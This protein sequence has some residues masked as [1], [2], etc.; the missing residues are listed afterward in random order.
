M[1]SSPERPPLVSP[2]RRASQ[3]RRRGRRV[4]PLSPRSA[5][6]PPRGACP[7]RTAARPRRPA[8]PATSA[9]PAT[10]SR[11][12]TSPSP[13]AATTAAAGRRHHH[14]RP[15]HRRAATPQPR[16]HPRHRP[17]RARST[18]RPP[19]SP[20]RARTW[21]SPP[22][23]RVPGGRRLPDHRRAHQRPG[24]DGASGG[25]VRTRDG[26]AMANQADAA[27]RV[28]PCNDH[29][30][31]KARF[32]FRDH[33]ARGTSRSSRT[34]CRPG[35]A[36]AGGHAPPGR[37]ASPTPWPPSSRRSPSAAPPCCTA[38]ARTGCRCATSCPQR[39]AR[40]SRTLAGEAPPGS[41]PGWRSK[42]GRYPFETYGVLIADATT[43][44]ELETQTLSLFETRPLHRPRLPAVVRRVDHG[45]RAGAPVV[46]R[47]RQPAPLV[48]PVAQRG[49]CHLVRGAVR[50]AARRD[51]PLDERMRARLRA[52]RRLARRRA[53]RPPRPSRPSPA[54]RSASSARSSTTAAPWSC[55]RCGRRSGGRR[56]S[57]WSGGGCAR[58]RDGVA[59]TADFVRLASEM[60]GRDLSGFL[61]PWLYGKTTPT[62]PGTRTG[63]P[64]PGPPEGP[65]RRRGERRTDGRTER[66]PGGRSEGPA[67][68]GMP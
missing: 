60:A 42:V 68:E 5:R 43:G 63:S 35:A 50:G 23:D 34:G 30:S 39:T 36:R 7:R 10:T 17:L 47:Q 54:S 62:M 28:F 37:T 66:F 22:R 11:P 3:D 2:A 64:T 31:D 12:T 51:E 56:S 13:T 18:A 29:P 9:T 19:G 45:A 38:P 16:L 48:R 25:W 58:H 52:V 6:P 27:H 4:P 26:L 20:P 15:R 21:S 1:P 57:G 33:R 32:T 8:L 49:P 14:R 40:R 61:R 65:W 24:G 53:A 59:S 44:F 46:R 67:A 55:T 41:W